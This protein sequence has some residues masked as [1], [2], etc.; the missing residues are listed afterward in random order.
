[1]NDSLRAAAEAVLRAAAEER[2]ISGRTDQW[3]HVL[4][5]A[6]Y[7]LEGALRGAE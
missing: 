6:L 3:G 1:V 5:D 2:R 7:A 4:D